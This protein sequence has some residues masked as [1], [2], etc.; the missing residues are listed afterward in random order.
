MTHK[1]TEDISQL[2][3]ITI[4]HTSDS[5]SIWLMDRL[6]RRF[7]KPL[8]HLSEHDKGRHSTHAGYNF[9]RLWLVKVLRASQVISPAHEISRH[10]TVRLV[11]RCSLE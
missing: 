9:T 1:V 10:I 5:D 8:L 3:L 11:I 7:I 4:E 2:L 6:Q